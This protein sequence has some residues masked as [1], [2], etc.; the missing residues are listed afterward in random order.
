MKRQMCAL[1]RAAAAATL[2][3]F[4][5][6]MPAFAHH[7]MDGATPE[8]FWQG[9]LS[10]L[11]HPVLGPDHALFLL[12]AGYLAFYLPVRLRYLVAAVVVV[13]AFAGTALHLAGAGFPLTESVIALSVLIGGLLVLR[14]RGLTPEGLSLLFAGFAVF[15]GYAYGQAII[16]AER[17]PL[18]A[19]FVGLSMVQYLAIIG[20]AG[21]IELSGIATNRNG[22]AIRYSGAVV[23]AIGCV[24]L[25]RALISAL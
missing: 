23:A 12:A 3:Q 10:G 11:A 21:L 24:L 9:L 13:G 20:I 1:V 7:A 8:T 25:S 15:H 14:R 18:V 22:S 5:T 16:G 4:A 6:P 2:L 19:Y 17:T